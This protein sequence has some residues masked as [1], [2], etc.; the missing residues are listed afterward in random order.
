MERQVAFAG[1]VVFAVLLVVAFVRGRRNVGRD[2]P[3]Q[4]NLMSLPNVQLIR[5]YAYPTVKAGSKPRVGIPAPT[6]VP[7]RFARGVYWV[8]TCL[9]SNECASAVLDTGS[10]NL[11]IGTTGCTGC[12]RREGLVAPPDNARVLRMNARVHYGSQSVIANVSLHTIRLAQLH[13]D[14]DR[15]HAWLEHGPPPPPQHTDAATSTLAPLPVA[16]AHD[17]EMFAT[18]QVT[19]STGVNVF[20][21]APGAG[22][23]LGNIFPPNTRR[24]YSVML[25]PRGGAWM[26]GSP[27][28]MGAFNRLAHIPLDRPRH[29]RE[30]PTRFYTARLYDIRV[31]HDLH[32]MFSVF[33]SAETRSKARWVMLDTGSTATYTSADLRAPLQAAGVGGSGERLSKF[34]VLVF[35]GGVSV[36]LE[37]GI[38]TKW[39]RTD[40]SFVGDVMSVSGVI[41]G[42]I[43]MRGLLIDFDEEGGRFGFASG[44][45]HTSP[46]G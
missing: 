9:A 45:G 44:R 30:L 18:H 17:V 7:L 28:V 35:A 4:P 43:A 12:S 27:P 5:P 39:L 21:I 19:G 15:L 3:Q 8:R 34:V 42:C 26:L 23:T 6:A 11:V 22:S 46:D 37:P 32:N 10:S 38:I 13:V 31:G 29:L 33:D 14:D 2:P 1:I 40:K 41:L 25:G 36:S 24:R 16:I 20:G